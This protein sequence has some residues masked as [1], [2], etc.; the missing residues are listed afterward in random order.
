MEHE[1]L[2]FTL[3]ERFWYAVEFIGEEFGDQI[4]SYSPIRVDE[5]VCENSGR[6]LFSLSFYHANYP[7]GVRDKC[8]TLQTIEDGHLSF[9][10]QH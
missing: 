4:R 8:Y 10:T 9:G 1:S 6:R 2:R 7:E 5:V 3:R